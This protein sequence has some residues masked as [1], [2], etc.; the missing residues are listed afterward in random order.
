MLFNARS[1]VNKAPLVRDLILDE[2]DELACITETWLGQEG[3]VPLSEMCPDG[4]QILHQPR[5]QGRGGGV[6]II[7]WKNL[8]PRR[9]PAPEIVGCESLLLK[10]DSKVQ[11]GLLLTYLPPSCIATALPALL[12]VIAGLAV[13]FPR[14]MVLGDFNLPSLS[15]HSEVAQEFV[16]SMAT[17]DLTQII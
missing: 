17:M 13:E 4:F 16:A 9:V 14:L 6:A 15:E 2:G 10:L 1:V 5:L 3:G 8:C 7:A 11:L 12:E